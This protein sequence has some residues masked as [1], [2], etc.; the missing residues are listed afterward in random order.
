MCSAI[1]AFP[2]ARAVVVPRTRFM[3]VKT[4]ND[5]LGLRSDAFALSDDATLRLAS[6]QAAPLID[7]DPAHYRLID[8]MERLIAGG[9]PSLRL[10]RSLRVKG[11]MIF[12]DKITFCGDIVVI[13]PTDAP[14]KLCPGNYCDQQLELDELKN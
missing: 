10:C 5:L 8:Q 4:T 2:G 13:N 14:K 9:I 7:L 1:E 6:K 12:C 11:P 3:P